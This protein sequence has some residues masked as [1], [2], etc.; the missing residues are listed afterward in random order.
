MFKRAFCNFRETLL[1]FPKGGS[2]YL[3]EATVMEPDWQKSLHGGYYARLNEVKSKCNS[4]DVFYATTAVGS[5]R[6]VVKDG[7]KGVQ[8]QNGR[9][10]R[11]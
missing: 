7:N 1:R 4:K 8:T 3:N 5:E 2:R 11:F 10:C 6:S 9:S